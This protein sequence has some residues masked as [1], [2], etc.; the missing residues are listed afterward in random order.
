M[1]G[2]D[3]WFYFFRLCGGGASFEWPR[4][5]P[6]QVRPKRKGQT[7]DARLVQLVGVTGAAAV[8]RVAVGAGGD[9]DFSSCGLVM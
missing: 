1:A 3:G 9:P 4:W 7:R 2:C 5:R 6:G 8:A